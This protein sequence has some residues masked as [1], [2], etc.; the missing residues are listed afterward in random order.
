M[1]ALDELTNEAQAVMNRQQELEEAQQQQEAVLAEVTERRERKQ[2]EVSA[3]P[4]H[5][6]CADQYS[7]LGSAV[8]SGLQAYVHMCRQPW[9]SMADELCRSSACLSC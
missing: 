4:G 8:T 2:N 3:G 7:A 9:G 1:A 6:Y 5:N